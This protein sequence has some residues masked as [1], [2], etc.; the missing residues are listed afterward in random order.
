MPLESPFIQV[1]V[2]P[3]E[4]VVVVRMFLN[5]GI[6][7]LEVPRLELEELVEVGILKIRP[8]VAPVRERALD[9]GGVAAARRLVTPSR[10]RGAT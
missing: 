8:E 3:M 1:A 9:E 2:A 4:R 5:I 7:P 10:R 6:K